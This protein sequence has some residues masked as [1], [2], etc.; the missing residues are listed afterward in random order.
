MALALVGGL[1]VI[2]DRKPASAGRSMPSGA[3]P[4]SRGLPAT[5]CRRVKFICFVISS[6]AAT[7]G[8][9]PAWPLAA[10][11]SAVHV[12][13]SQLRVP[14]RCF[15]AVLGGVSLAAA[16]GGSWAAALAFFISPFVSNGCR[17]C[18]NAPT[19]WQLV[20]TGA[21]HSSRPWHI[22]SKRARN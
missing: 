20:I 10:F 11:G 6:L 16:I 18:M 21:N 3:M 5:T 14:G 1:A 8:G 15:A 19:E 4:R 9:H 13:G 2:D 12:A 17:E 22:D 7:V